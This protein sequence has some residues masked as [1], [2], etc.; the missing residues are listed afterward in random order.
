MVDAIGCC[1]I[2]RQSCFAHVWL[3]KNCYDEWPE[4]HGPL[5][6]WPDWAREMA[7]MH[8]AERRQE[9]AILDN[10]AELPM[11]LVDFLEV[12]EETGTDW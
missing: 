2:C 4:L 11:D 1:M 6:D 3:C 12:Q 9:H 5:K 8:Q 7:T 10:E